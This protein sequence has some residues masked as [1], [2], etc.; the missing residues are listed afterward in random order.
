MH[1]LFTYG[2]LQHPDIQEKV[3][4]RILVGTPDVLIGYEKGTVEIDGQIF[5]IADPKQDGKI[6]GVVYTLSQEELEKADI[7]EGKEYRRVT[8]TL[9]S[10][11]ESLVYVRA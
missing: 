4:N 6:E 1:S 7:Y 5:G 2:T 10:G 9:E 3:F 8:H 11:M